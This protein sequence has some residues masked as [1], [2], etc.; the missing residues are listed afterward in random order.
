MALINGGNIFHHT[1]IAM[2]RICTVLQFLGNET[3]LT[4]L[5]FKDCH[6]II[7]NISIYNIRNV[8]LCSLHLEYLPTLQFKV[9]EVFSNHASFIVNGVSFHGLECLDGS[10]QLA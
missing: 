8:C 4:K 7:S 6:H 10:L 2:K 5:L 9:K 3:N 1:I